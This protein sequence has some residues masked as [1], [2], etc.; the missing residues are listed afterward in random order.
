MTASDRFRKKIKTSG[1]GCWEWTGV[2]NHAGY[3]SIVVN[4]KK[5][6]AHRYSYEL[7]VG[8]IKPG[9]V[10]DHK[11]RNRSCVNPYHLEQATLKDNSS[12]T[13]PGKNATHCKRGHELTEDNIYRQKYGRSCKACS[14]DRTVKRR[15]RLK[16]EF[17]NGS[18]W[19]LFV[20]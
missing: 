10:I 20:S 13:A 17:P 19:L 3:G 11:C 12:R 7:L 14:M 8:T 16:G 9:M 4:G 1:A 6:L 2:K 15:N 18:A 5:L